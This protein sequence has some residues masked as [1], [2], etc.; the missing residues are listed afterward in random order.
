MRPKHRV[1]LF[2]K[3]AL[4]PELKRHPRRARTTQSLRLQKSPQLR[5]IR[6]EVRRQLKQQAPQPSRSPHRLQSPY[7]NRKFSGVAASHPASIVAVGSA[8]NV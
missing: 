7:K 6:F 1:R 8:R 2:G 4:V 3:P 5:R